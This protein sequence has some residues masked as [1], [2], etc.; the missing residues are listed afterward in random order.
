MDMSPREVAVRL[1]SEKG[2]ASR[3]RLLGALS[4]P[5]DRALAVELVSGAIKWR[6]LI[7]RELARISTRP[8]DRLSPR[9]LSA[10]RIGVFQLLFTNM[11]AY[12]AVDST[13]ECLRAHG[14]RAFANAVL[15]GVSRSLGHVELPSI[16]EDEALYG[17]LRYS[18]PTWI[19][20]T[21][22]ER[23][24]LGD[25][26]RL[27]DM[28]NRPAQLTLRVNDLRVPV[29]VYLRM[30]RERGI[31]AELGVSSV[32]LRLKKGIDV[33][34]LPG[35]R[36]GL[37]AVQDEGAIAV[38][39]AMDL[40]PIDEVWDVCAAPGGKTTH[41]AQMMGGSGYVLATD[42][43]EERAAMIRENVS[44]LALG[45]VEVRVLDAT[46]VRIGRLFDRVLV[47]A[48]CSGLGS[49][50]RNPDLRWNHRPEDIPKMVERQMDLLEAA[51]EH[52]RAGGVLVYST[53][54]LT[55]AENEDVFQA[56]LERHREFAPEDPA[57]FDG[58]GA[59]RLFA[60]PPF[61]GPGY[62]YIPPH[63]S[64]TDGFFVARAMKRR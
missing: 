30:L 19:V 48:P 25:A 4:D 20:S 17:A 3:D 40:S 54:T 2:G 1:L 55:K 59:R 5:R 34:S 12:A 13:V 10:L 58:Q 52:L 11:P 31:E 26:L 33:T 36:E 57:G 49:I 62:R 45:N 44:R 39:E 9:L 8:L 53:C 63:L 29:G 60:G 38:G 27:L 64:G 42:V 16:D 32:S 35:F 61:S 14:E 43:D 18:Y 46:R 51:A 23:F 6:R 37:F 7:D 21:F 56:F 41:L 47:D 28:G 22:I 15:R 24:G 50:R